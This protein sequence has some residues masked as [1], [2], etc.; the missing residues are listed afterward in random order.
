MKVYYIFLLLIITSCG[1]NHVRY[2]DRHG[3]TRKDLKTDDKLNES[4]RK[5]E[6]EL[7]IHKPE[8]SIISDNASLNTD[9]DIQ[10]PE[11]YP[12]ENDYSV[13]NLVKNY[14][15]RE[16]NELRKNI[17]EDK[18]DI[19]QS[20]PVGPIVMI[21]LGVIIFFGAL[22]YLYNLD[23]FI[24]GYGCLDQLFTLFLYALIAV[25]LGVGGLVLI[26]IGT[27]LLSQYK[28]RKSRQ[29]KE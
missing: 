18:K 7:D 10:T 29:N 1:H 14:D 22:I 19:E 25:L 27:I 15:I 28:R 17:K 26:I 24:G 20:V 3:Q 5:S 12:Y 13:K 2:G 4:S 11:N 6:L 23:S 9:L 21:I 8:T 16:L